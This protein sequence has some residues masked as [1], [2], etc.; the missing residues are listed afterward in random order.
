MTRAYE[1]KIVCGTADQVETQVKD[2]TAG[3]WVIHGSHQAFPWNGGI[4]FSQTLVKEYEQPGAW[5]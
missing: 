3:G 2:L 1:F 4:T 5:G